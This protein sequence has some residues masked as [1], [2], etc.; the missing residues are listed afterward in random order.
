MHCGR[1]GNPTG[2]VTR[3][4]EGDV[5]REPCEELMRLIVLARKTRRDVPAELVRHAT[6]ASPD[7]IEERAGRW[8]TTRTT[9]PT[10]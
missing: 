1:C 2:H 9:S 8:Q 4:A 7:D 6:E 3:T 10:Q 5:I